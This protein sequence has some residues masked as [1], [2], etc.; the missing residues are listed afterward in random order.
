MNNQEIGFRALVEAIGIDFYR[1]H[2]EKAV[3]SWGEE[4]E[5]LYCFLGIDLHPERHGATLSAQMTDWDYYASCY[6]SE[7]GA[8]TMDDCRLPQTKDMNMGQ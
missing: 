8:V 2:K 4:D 1:S 7:N 5:G 3:F 6:V